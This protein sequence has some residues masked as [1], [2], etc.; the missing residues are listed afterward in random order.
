MSLTMGL[1]PFLV[2]LS[3]VIGEWML[4]ANGSIYPDQLPMRFP[5]FN[6]LLYQLDIQLYLPFYLAISL[7]ALAEFFLYNT[8]IRCCSWLCSLCY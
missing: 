6:G 3:P 5:Y 2:I 4:A 7:L 8:L 1:I